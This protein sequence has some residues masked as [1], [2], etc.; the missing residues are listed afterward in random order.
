MINVESLGEYHYV[1]GVQVYIY[2]SIC[3]TIKIGEKKS[4]FF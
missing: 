1:L 3:D 4:Y 2:Y